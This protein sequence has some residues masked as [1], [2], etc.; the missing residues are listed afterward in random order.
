MTNEELIEEILHEAHNLGFK[1]RI[2]EL[3]HELSKDN[4]HSNR[5][6]I[7]EKALKIIKNEQKMVYSTE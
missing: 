5:V 6:D 2:F 1:T 3:F 4:P 7:Y